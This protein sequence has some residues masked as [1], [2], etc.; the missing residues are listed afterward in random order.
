MELPVIEKYIEAEKLAADLGLKMIYGG[1]GAVRLNTVNVSRPGLLLAGFTDYFGENR[2]QVLGNAE[3]EYLLTMTHTV[4]RTKLE[5]LAQQEVPCIV[6][7]RSREPFEELLDVVHRY[8][9]PLF[10]TDNSTSSLINRLVM[11]LNKLLAPSITRHAGLLDVYGTGI[12][13]TGRSGIGKSE[14][15]LEMVKR[16]HRLIADDS[17]IVNRIDD[18]LL[19]TSPDMIRYFMEIR[20]IGIIDVRMLY[21]V[22]SVMQE[23]EIELVVELETW[24][25]S[26]F[27]DRLGD[28]PQYE[29]ILGVTLPKLII[30]VKPGR[31]LSIILEAAA[32]NSR[33]KEQGYD[34]AQELINRTMGGNTK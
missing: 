21:G 29:E 24:D 34:A 28:K 31:N 32:R 4:R 12:L 18:R 1:K 15:A 10:V 17:V 11:Y 27:Y 30:P 26:K 22:G 7:S 23:K 5:I 6:I 20:G 14:T 25:D 3:F 2:I 9:I 19:G 16:G 33:L 13:L 8:E